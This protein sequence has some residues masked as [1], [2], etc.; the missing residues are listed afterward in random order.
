MADGSDGWDLTG[1]PRPL[2]PYV[3]EVL[4]A[5]ELYRFA[6]QVDKATGEALQGVAG[7]LLTNGAA[8]I[9]ELGV[10]G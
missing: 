1:I 10:R 7:K 5:R 9:A 6:G 2:W 4:V 3:R 8:K